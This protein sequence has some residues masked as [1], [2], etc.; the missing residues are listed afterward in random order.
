[1]S[2]AED[3][4]LALAAETSVHIH[5]V[6]DSDTHYIIDPITRQ[7]S[8][9]NSGKTVIMQFDHYS[10]Q[11]TF[12]IPRYVDG[13]DM[14][15]CNS[16]RVHFI[17]I[18]SEFE[19]HT[20]LSYVDNLGVNPEDPTTVL[21]TWLIP[22]DAT[23]LVGPLNFLVQY[24]CV[25]ENG[26]LTYEWHTDINT[27]NTVRA[28]M[29]N[30]EEVI[31]SYPDVLEQWRADLFGAGDSVLA[32]IAEA[33]LYGMETVKET[34]SAKGREVLNSIP[35]DYTT[36]HNL[37]KE[38]A[39][40]KA[41]AILMEVEGENITVDDSED[42][43]AR[44]LRV[45][46]KTT[47]KVV[48][49][50]NLFDH[51][52]TDKTWYG[53][54]I[55]HDDDG[56]IYLNGTCTAN[57][58]TKVSFGTTE[59]ATED[60]YCMSG[61]KENLPSGQTDYAYAEVPS[62]SVIYLRG[63][64]TKG[65]L[66]A[67]TCNYGV[68]L[69]PRATYNNTRIRIQLEKSEV[70]TEFEIYTGGVPGPSP[71]YPIPLDSIKPTLFIYGKNLIKNDRYAGK[72][73]YVNGVK[74]T[75]NVDKSITVSGTPTGAIAWN[76]V[77]DMPL[78]AGTYTLSGAPSN[79]SSKFR[80]QVNRKSTID[81]T[82]STGGV[83]NTD[84]AR[85]SMPEDG[86]V[87]EYI[88]VAA[89]AGAVSGTFYPQLERGSNATEYEPYKSVQTLDLVRDIPG[90]P[91][92]TGGSYTDSNGQQWI[93]DEI[94]F[95]RGVYIQRVY[96]E[97]VSFSAEEDTN[98]IRYRAFLTYNTDPVYNGYIMCAELPYNANA[99]PGA[100]GIRISTYSTNLAIAYY[101]D[102]V[103][104]TATVLYPLQTPIETPLTVDELEAFEVLRTH[105]TNTTVFNDRGAHMVLNY[106]GDIKRY[107]EKLPKATDE[108]VYAAVDAWLTEHFASAEGVSF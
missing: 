68:Y 31:A 78:P 2:R 7:V 76:I 35:E 36:T 74:F 47:Q 22:R 16:V 102:R 13:H 54:T 11:F 88:Y 93:C 21:C 27:D 49:G 20:G 81:G 56:Y 79:A 30:S 69:Y 82:E 104:T 100:N 99:N 42:A 106:N 66:T 96:C 107:L 46:G 5:P 84:V 103:L 40:A 44:N 75:T 87:R 14:L 24:A 70:V 17:N 55:T 61:S 97:E 19:Q 73:E 10:E 59:V 23:Q 51:S 89:D 48:T 86:Y 52:S 80:L 94:D 43:Y 3:L 53:V 1:M 9:P 15:L 108:Q 67:G 64:S 105:H 90:L 60:N 29:K 8:N 85:F 62:N 95:E 32:D 33:R 50:K 38:G 39:H 45:F 37:A 41:N 77:D 26:H 57:A 92:D 34:I 18:Y 65:S 83:N 6:V 4:L 58:L 63:N 12:E 25:D 72:I 28:G 98:G 71:A 101:N 91:V